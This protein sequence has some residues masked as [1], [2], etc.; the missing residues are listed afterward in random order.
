MIEAALGDGRLQANLLGNIQNGPAIGVIDVTKQDPG[1][2]DLGDILEIP[3][4]GLDGLPPALLH[5]HR[6]HVIPDGDEIRS[7]GT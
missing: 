4:D 2:A 1:E 6:L 5:E 3:A 7:I